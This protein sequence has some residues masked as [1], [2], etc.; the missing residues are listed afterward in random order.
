MILDEAYYEWHSPEEIE[1]PIEQ[2]IVQDSCCEEHMMERLV[3]A[4]PNLD[5]NLWDTFYYGNDEDEIAEDMERH[6]DERRYNMKWLN[7]TIDHMEDRNYQFEPF[8]KL[9]NEA[10]WIVKDCVEKLKE[11]RIQYIE[12][13][14]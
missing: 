6:K 3:Q 9:G 1:D 4:Y 13:E 2:K 10:Y 8:E 11:L 7:N 12:E 14:M 5:K